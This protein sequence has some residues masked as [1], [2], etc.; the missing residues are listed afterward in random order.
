MN[1]SDNL[2][3]FSSLGG[4]NAT[5]ANN[6]ENYTGIGLAK[7]LQQSA[8]IRTGISAFAKLAST[9]SDYSSLRFNAMQKNIQARQ[10]G[11][12]ALEQSNALREKVLSNLSNALTNT[13]RRGITSDS[14]SVVL[15]MENTLAKSGEDITKIQSNA[16][17]EKRVLQAEQKMIN[18][19][20]K[21]KL[22]TGLLSG[23]QGLTS[24][25]GTLSGK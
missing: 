15:S 24:S 3:I 21:S 5:T 11:I 20:A 12:L 19:S 14:S 23:V 16:D 25:Y 22:F 13:S 9:F 1:N 2:S 10:V 7:Q 4:F 8:G 6:T 18:R 17:K